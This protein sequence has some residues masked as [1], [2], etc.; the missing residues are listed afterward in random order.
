MSDILVKFS[1]GCKNIY[2]EINTIFNW[3]GL[4]I[5]I[6]GPQQSPISPELSADYSPSYTW[7]FEFYWLM[8]HSSLL[9]ADSPH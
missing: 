9:L 8:A 4:K 5:L 1:Y 6:A 2:F 7:K 3:P